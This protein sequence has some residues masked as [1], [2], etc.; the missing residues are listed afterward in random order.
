MMEFSDDGSPIWS[1]KGKDLLYGETD[2]SSY[3]NGGMRSTHTAGGYLI[4]DPTS[5]IFLRD[6]T[7]FI[8]ACLQSFDGLALDEKT[9]L[10]RSA[11]ALSN[12]GSRLL[13]NLGY[14]SCNKIVAKIGL[15]QEIF[16]VN[17]ESYMK[18][19]DLQ[20]TGRTLMGKT[21]SRGQEMN[22]HYMAPPSLASPAIETLKEF[23]TSCFEMGIPMK[24]R[25]REV[26]PNQYEFAP[27]FGI[28]NTQ[29]DQNLM[30][31]QMIE[32]IAHSHGLACLLHEKPFKGVNGSG[33][34]NNWSLATDD[35]INLLN[36]EEISKKTGNNHI[37]PVIMAAIIK[38]VS[39][40][41]DLLRMA[42]ATPGNE[43][44]LGACEAPPAIIS[45][46]LGDDMTN[47]LTKYMNGNDNDNDS[48]EYIPNKKVLPRAASCLP[49]LTVPAEDRNRTSPFPYGGH[50]FEF[51]AVGSSQNVSMVNIVLATSVSKIFNEF[52]IAIENGMSPREVASNALKENF[53]VI[54][55]GNGYDIN[56]QDMLTK[57]GLCRIDNTIDAIKCMNS[58]KNKILFNDMNIFNNNECDART[59]IMLEHY[60]GVV[61]ME[62]LTMIDM[63]NQNVIP[64][65]LDS[66]DSIQN[67]CPINELKLGMLNI[68]QHLN[69]IHK[70]NNIIDKSRIANTLRLDIMEKIRDL[71]DECEQIVPANKWTLATYKDLLFLDHT[72]M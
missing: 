55:N 40:Y 71:C 60:I 59:D 58:N 72:S 7:I 26:A 24:T 45:T 65:C 62:A 48:I 1:F 49:P 2:G 66:H 63:I 56:N 38:A 68:K 33:K 6:D 22:D 50:R 28:M 19:P 67:A 46:H 30:A 35:G 11:D 41:G 25:H 27:C 3:S 34:H 16:L 57:K 37:F 17:R 64:S 4:I 51:R 47:Y 21:P 10:L 14:K 39:Q 23:Q 52:N 18:R 44:R 29:I 42:I 9:P 8:P 15:E 43:F 13:K 53:H 31:M 54:F 12:E 32:E 69:S 70:S 61:E 20:M 36:V 5:P